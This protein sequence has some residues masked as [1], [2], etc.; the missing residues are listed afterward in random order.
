LPYIEFLALQR[1]AMVVIT[2]SGGIQEETTYLHVPC[3]TLRGNTERPV[4]VALGT[5]VLVG[6]NSDAL[7]EAFRKVLAGKA[8]RGTIPPLWDGKA[9]ERIAEILIKS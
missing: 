5:N 8:K 2:D 6:Q 4:T 7:R 3:I 1:R 9:G